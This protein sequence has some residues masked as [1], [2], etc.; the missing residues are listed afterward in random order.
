M[1][2]IHSVLELYG[3]YRPV[4]V[5]SMVLHDFEN[6]GTFTLPRLRTRMLSTKLRDA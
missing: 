1:Q 6:S 2:Y 5:P 3:L 4:G